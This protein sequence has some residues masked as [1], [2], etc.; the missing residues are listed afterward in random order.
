M[1]RKIKSIAFYYGLPLLAFALLLLLIFLIPR[2]FPIGLDLTWLIILTMIATAWYFGRGPGLVF[3]VLFELTLIYFSTQ[4]FTGKSLVITFNRLVL[5]GSVVLFAS[6]R[7]NA[8]RKLREQ[9]ELLQVT[10]ASIGDAVIAT[11]ARGA[12]NFINQPAETLTGW[13]KTEAAG[14]PL[15][16]VFPII[17]EETRQ[18]VESPFAAV[19]REG[20]VVGLANHTLLINKN[21]KEIPIEDSGAPIKDADGAIVGVVLVFHDVTER[22][23]IEKER[24]R[25]LK[26]EQSA[27]NEAETAGRIKDEFLAT[28]S[29]ELRTPLSAILGWSSMLKES[30][31]EEK[32]I[33]N[34]LGIIE[35]N[36]KAQAEVIGD[37]L[38]VSSIITGKMQID[39]Q[40]VE[41]APIVEAAAE[42][43]RPAAAAKSIAL[44][45][46]INDGKNLAL[47]DA[48]RLRQIV[49]NLIS[50]AIKFT[51]E[52]GSVEV[53]LGEIGSHL[54]ISVGDTGIGIDK[55]LLPFIF[56]RFRQGD[57]STTRAHGGLGLGLAIVRHLVELHGGTVRAESNGREQGSTF[58]VRLPIADRQNK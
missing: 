47:G 31:L 52:N 2:V 49:W 56:E 14:K 45:V 41:L 42:K 15:D 53:R 28:V 58:T 9:K 57:S 46:S 48:D 29:H 36:A 30:N 1:A 55:K 23:R 40:P 8:E 17:N 54:E 27:R 19:I 20:N 3:A 32:T 5:F 50:N 51:P 38:D 33:R 22:R 6:A 24:E 43:L 16:E 4:P 18:P 25:L 35:R 10:L 12:I 21:G 34:A 39:A 37:I 26:R 7:R 13:T 11:D 44:T